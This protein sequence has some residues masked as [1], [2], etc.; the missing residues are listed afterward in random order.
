VATYRRRRIAPGFARQ[1]LAIRGG[2]VAIHIGAH[3]GL[4]RERQSHGAIAIGHEAL[5]LG[6][7]TPAKEL[8][9]EIIAHERWLPHVLEHGQ[10]SPQRQQ[11]S[12]EGCLPFD[13]LGCARRALPV[14]EEGQEPKIVARRPQ[15]LEGR[16]AFQG[17]GQASGGVSQRC[18]AI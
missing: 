3:H 13:G 7:A 17:K 11:S 15:P 6:T 8:T 9:P 10:A 2:K 16:H 14:V 4:D 12:D 18:I 1:A 5:Q